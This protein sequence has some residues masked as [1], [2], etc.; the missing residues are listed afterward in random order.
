MSAKKDTRRVLFLSDEN[1]HEYSDPIANLVEIPKIINS[2]I[3]HAL[4]LGQRGVYHLGGSWREMM[5]YG[6]IEY[7]VISSG[8]KSD[9]KNTDYDE[10]YK[11]ISGS[12]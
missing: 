5:E 7:T 4:E 12:Y 10:L 1:G 8:R 11:L 9:Y 2:S 3:L 6:N